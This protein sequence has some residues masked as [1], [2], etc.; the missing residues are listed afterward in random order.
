MV[1]DRNATATM[2]EFYSYCYVFLPYSRLMDVA[3]CVRG[4]WFVIT[5]ILIGPW[6]VASTEREK[7]WLDC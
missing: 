2:F 7:V 5:F 3:V 1:K 4:V 6:I